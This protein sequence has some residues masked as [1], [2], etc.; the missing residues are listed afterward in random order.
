VESNGNKVAH[1][2][3]STGILQ[4]WSLPTANALP[5][6][7]AATTIGGQT[8]VWGTE[9]NQAKIFAFFPA[10]STFKEYALPPGTQPQYISIEPPGA[11]TR[12]WFSEFPLN[13]G[14]IV[15][16][17]GPSV[18]YF[19]DTFP[20]AVGAAVNGVW[21]GAGNI[22]FAGTA[23]IARWD[24]V[25]N[26]YTIWPI[27]THG[28]ATA[29]FLTLDAFG[30]IWYTQRSSG[31]SSTDNYVG[32]IRGDNTIK[33]WQIPT[34]GA[35]PRVIAFNAI[36]GHPWV[37]EIM[38][39][40][41]G[42]KI[43]E[44]DPT[45]GGAV[46]GAGPSTVASGGSSSSIP[47][48]L[49]GPVPVSTST[50]APATSSNT[51]TVTGQFTEWT[52]ASG[53]RPH[54]VVIDSSGTTWFLE[55]GA[56]KI[57]R[58]TPTAPDF[59][60][61]AGSASITVA[62]G[63]SGTNQ[64]TG[65][66]ILG[67]AGAVT[68]SLTGSVP[69]GVTASFNPNPIS[70]PSGGNAASTATINVASTVPPG[71]YP[72]TVSGTGGPTHTATF[73]LTV[74]SGADFSLSLS[75][76]SVS[77]SAGGSGTVSVTVQSLGSFSSAVT[78]ST[79]P[80]PSGVSINFSPSSV[81]PPAGGSQSSTATINVAPGTPASSQSITIT[82]TSGSLAHSQPFTLT[83]TVTPDFALSATPPSLTVTQ[84]GSASSSIAVSSVNGFSAPVTLTPSWFGSAPTDVTFSVTSPV[85]PPSGSSASSPLTV[86]AGASASTGTFTLRITGSSGSLTH[87]V[88]V[89][90]VI[91]TVGGTTTITTA[92]PG[93]S[94][95][96]ATAT[97]G[98]EMAGEVQLLRTFRDNALMKTRAGSSFMT[99]FN[100]WYYSFSPS[101]ALQVSNS[102]PERA[103]L[104]VTL[105]PLIGILSLSSQVF[106]TFS[107]NPELAT[108]MSGLTASALLGF[109]Y[110]GLPF[111]L[112]SMKL[113]RLRDERM[114]VLKVLFAT[115]SIAFVGLIVGELFA[116]TA[117]LMAST[118][119][120]V[121]STMFL[122]AALVSQ[123]LLR[124]V[125]RFT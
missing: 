115:F 41:N 19:E 125:K 25:A 21:A 23:G 63:S 64:I 82:G 123:V 15:Y 18:T 101:V 56:N 30:Q 108:V 67:F 74:T 61:T 91:T 62:Q 36:T 54:P 65:T 24:R 43:A 4:E 49:S 17:G 76:G 14:E 53:S 106:S 89:T 86:N 42:G 47:E 104:R 29:A 52:L 60:L 71:T 31:A 26:Q 1:F 102:P 105:T 75:T 34:A 113:A 121:L 109:V 92:P 38:Q 87:S 12:V 112:A 103:L 88:D 46:V 97:Y 70:I 3:P 13:N 2:D 107:S 116:S 35:D 98:S 95:L 83:I 50:P 73:S 94:C 68:L 32:V 93:P 117:L 10:T 44:L 90:I 40:A 119:T 55:S 122:S 100:A 37:A 22:Y 80:L 124:V 69:A 59:S 96:V 79:S 81:T 66:S 58:L 27:P 28:S 39:A 5:T 72:I 48:A 77:V 20:G 6:S 33:E 111:G 78:F 114:R 84:G 85:T 8:V 110:L 11:N 118:S 16:S 51:G 7:L 57:G 120:A 99:A 9:F 45:S